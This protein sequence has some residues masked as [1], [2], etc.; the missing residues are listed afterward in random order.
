[1]DILE[2][3]KKRKSIRKFKPDPISKEIFSEILEMAGQSPSSVNS[4]PWEFAVLAGDVLEN[5]KRANV[6]MLKAE[7]PPYPEFDLGGLPRDT[8]YRDRQI[9]LAKGIF[10]LMDIARE[11]K[12]KR[13]EWMERGFRF[14]DAPAAILIM[15][16]R[17][18]DI[19]GPLLDLGAA[20]QTICLAALNFDL[21]T[22]IADQ[23]IL[24]PGEVRKFAD[25]PEEKQIVISIS[26]GYPDWDFPANRLE[27][28]REPVDKTTS[29]FGI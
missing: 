7:T 28:E 17:S 5:V 6:E 13:A 12:E 9:T 21:G 29:W 8:V 26:I 15:Q 20:M 10:K 23:G 22:C 14:F 3:V 1:M 11:D 24:Y 19:T 27:T 18:L 2:V 16:D 4:Q 25:I